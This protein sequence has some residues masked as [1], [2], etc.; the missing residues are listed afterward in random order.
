MA[1]LAKIESTQPGAW[2]VYGHRGAVQLLQHLTQS[3]AHQPGQDILHHAYLFWGPRQIGKSTLVRAFAQAILC[4]GGPQRPCGE[5]RA[6][7]LMS[8]GV[9]PDYRLIQPVDKSGAVDRLDGTLRVEQAAEIIRDAL[10]RPV[11]GR[12]KVFFLQD[13][14]NAND[15]F[16]NKLLKTLEEPPPHVVIC[17]TALERTSVLPTIVSRCQPLE[18]RPL[19][20]AT[21]TRGLMEGWQAPAEQAGLLARL[22]NGRLGW[23]V[24]Q[25]QHPKGQEERVQQLQTLWRLMGA[26]RIERLAFAEQLAAQRNSQQLFGLLELWAT[27]C[28]DLLLVQNDCLELCCNVDQQSTLVQQARTVTAAAIQQ[29]LHALKRIEGYLHHTVNTRL[30]LDVLLLQLPVVMQE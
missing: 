8:K 2:P 14:Q 17:V 10:L 30:A 11:E 1:T 13:V 20:V 9:H 16:A 25:L 29:Y 3:T 24:E 22:A 15:G 19:D 12:Y 21:I 5:C 26:N 28:R 18:L 4:M 27:W 23:A 7:R 6:C